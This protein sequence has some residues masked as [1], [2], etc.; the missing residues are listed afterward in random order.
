MKQVV[1]V[2]HKEFRLSRTAF[3]G[4][5]SRVRHIHLQTPSTALV[6]G[7]LVSLIISLLNRRSVDAVTRRIY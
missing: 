3:D 1:S 4:K 2:F 5:L 6:L 7:S